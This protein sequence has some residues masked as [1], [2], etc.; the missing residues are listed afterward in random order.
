VRGRSARRDRWHAVVHLLSAG[1]R[2]G[3]FCDRLIKAVRFVAYNEW[4]NLVVA[5]S[6][7]APVT[8]PQSAVAKVFVELA[9]NLV[10]DFD[11]IDFLDLVTV[12]SAQALNVEAVGMLLAHTDDD[13]NVVAA[14]CETMRVLELFQ[15]QSD[16]GPGLDCYLTGRPVNCPD[17]SCEASRWPGFVSQALDAGFAAVH[18][19]PMRSYDAT[20]GQ[21]NLLTATHGGLDG[22]Q[23][24]VAQAFTDMATIGVM[25]ARAIRGSEL[26][27]K[28]LHTALN[29][30]V[31]IEQAKGILAGRW[32]ITVGEASELLRSYAHG[33]NQK[34]T[35]VAEAVVRNDPAMPI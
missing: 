30:R 8:R 23:L 21:I 5:R 1:F 34:L 35:E 13:L 25:G 6:T 24:A 4:T 33:R 3:L 29:S 32:C 27:I 9:D 20:I 10:T 7:K 18:A 28:Q 17:L 15:L 19:L 11:L 14:S 26:L 22:E 31:T 2:K 12:R 16:E